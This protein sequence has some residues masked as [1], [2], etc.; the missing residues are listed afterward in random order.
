VNSC[1]QR[2]EGVNTTRLPRCGSSRKNCSSSAKPGGAAAEP[3]TVTECFR[4]SQDTVIV[5]EEPPGRASSPLSRIWK[6][7]V[8]F[9]RFLNS[10]NVCGGNSKVPV[11]SKPLVSKRV[12]LRRSPPL[13][14]HGPDACKTQFPPATDAPGVLDPEPYKIS[15]RWALS[16][17]GAVKQPGKKMRNAIATLDGRGTIHLKGLEAA[18]RA[19]S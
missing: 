19:V 18:T 9:S 11:V 7:R 17:R 3:T 12:A 10:S 2:G 13:P 4:P 16:S 6:N 14:V 15:N 8:D 1:G 5:R